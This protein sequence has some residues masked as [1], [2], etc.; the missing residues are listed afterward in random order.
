[1]KIWNGML[2]VALTL[3]L[4]LGVLAEDGEKKVEKKPGKGGEKAAPQVV[5]LPKEIELSAE[6]K[7]K[8]AAINKEFAPKMADANKALNAVL[9]EDQRKARAEAM[10]KAREEGKKGKDAAE[11]V[12]AA[13]KV[14]DDQKAKVDEAQK[15][16]NAVRK[17]AL[18]KVAAV[19]TDDQ[20]AKVPQLQ[21]GK[22]K[23]KPKGEKKPGE[24]K[25]EEKAVK[26]E[27]KPVDGEKKPVEGEKKPVEKKAE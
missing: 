15:A 17:E 14:T 1:M 22:G 21:Q 5:Q 9:T 20:K 25:P 27:K 4:S 3:V 6:Q 19:L 12:A 18:E 11:A 7:E 13:T 16:V 10:K 24:K 26:A 23:G 2:S 8:V